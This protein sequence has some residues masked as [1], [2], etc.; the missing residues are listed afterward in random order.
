VASRFVAVLVSVVC[1]K[2]C[3]LF[4]NSSL[5]TVMSSS[6]TKKD[7][8][9]SLKGLKEKFKAFVSK[10]KKVGGN[11]KKP[12]KTKKPKPMET[13]ASTSAARPDNPNGTR[14]DNKFYEDVREC[15]SNDAERQKWDNMPMNLPYSRD[16]V[17]R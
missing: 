8:N 1:L 3:H 13:Q 7:G 6:A 14:W 17:R 5:K 4:H 2:T 12:K 10:T 9:N 16:R 15:L 11:N